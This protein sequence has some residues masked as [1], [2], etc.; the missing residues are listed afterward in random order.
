[1]T[2]KT[3]RRRSGAAAVLS[4]AVLLAGALPPAARGQSPAPAAGAPAPSGDAASDQPRK[5]AD[6]TDWQALAIG[7]GE[8][9]TC[10]AALKVPPAADG[11]EGDAAEARNRGRPQLFVT[12][13]PGRNMLNVVSYFASY[14][15]RPDGDIDL[16]FG[17]ARFRLFTQA[18]ID[19][20]WSGSADLDLRIVDAMKAGSSVTARGTDAAGNEMAETF[21][22]MGFTA[23]LQRITR[24][25]PPR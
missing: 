15:V 8:D 19:G 25:C 18:G 13:R 2:C 7:A 14:A 11:R 17:T 6:D 21:S 10:Y 5:L 4:A 16:D 9:R 3:H 23:A 24:E 22:L 1:M 20:A 12:H